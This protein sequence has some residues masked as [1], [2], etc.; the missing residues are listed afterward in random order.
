MQCC[1][2]AQWVQIS[3]FSSCPQ[4]FLRWRGG[5]TLQSNSMWEGHVRIVPL[6]P[7]LALL[8]KKSLPS[9]YVQAWE[10]HHPRARVVDLY[11]HATIYR[12]GSTLTIFH[13]MTFKQRRLLIFRLTMFCLE[14]SDCF[15]VPWQLIYTQM[16]IEVGVNIIT[17][18]QLY[19]SLRKR[20][21][22]MHAL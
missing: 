15:V 11:C 2:S 21:L 20:F 3:I 6:N 4:L 12:Y 10:W 19:V 7:P 1:Q 17:L 22:I 13:H 14:N 8:K 5:Q 16:S 18:L 9:S